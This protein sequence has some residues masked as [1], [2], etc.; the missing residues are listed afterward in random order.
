M[1][2][3][4]QFF[5]NNSVFNAISL[6]L[7]VT[8]VILAV[9]FYLAS[10]TAPDLVYTVH[11]ARTTIVR[12]DQNS[13]LHIELDGKTVHGDITAVQIAFWNNGSRAIRPNNLLRAFI[14]GQSYPI[15]D[16]EIQK[17]SREV[18][19]LRLD[20]SRIDK[21]QLGVEWTILEQDDGAVLQLI[22]S[23]GARRRI[24]ASAIVENQ[25]E[26]REP[27]RERKNR[28]DKIITF[29][30]ALGLST[31]VL[32][33]M[34]GAGLVTSTIYSGF[35]TIMVLIQIASLIVAGFYRFSAGPSPPF[36]WS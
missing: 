6:I 8:G 7:G 30:M 20:T 11:S 15:I 31:I 26:L 3:F 19:G 24:T 29:N 1:M 13:R 16:A 25:G 12:M 23:G 14:T 10:R 32:I 21:G 34:R 22:Y 17:V 18:V 36:G 35:L 27:Q 4:K 5:N 28:Q 2:A 33:A 9:Y